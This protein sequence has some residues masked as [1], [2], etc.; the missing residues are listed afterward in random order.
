MPAPP[1]KGEVAVQTDPE[2]PSISGQAATSLELPQSQL[3][4]EPESQ[5]LSSQDAATAEQQAAK[6]AGTVPA[7]SE[8]ASVDAQA[9]AAAPVDEAD[10][11]AMVDDDAMDEWAEEEVDRELAR[12]RKEL[13]LEVGRAWLLRRPGD[14]YLH[15]T[16]MRMHV[17][18][19]IN[20]P[21]PICLTHFV[22]TCWPHT[23]QDSDLR[24]SATSL[25]SGV[26]VPALLGDAAERRATSQL[27]R[28]AADTAAAAALSLAGTGSTGAAAAAA[29]AA[30]A[31][32]A[33]EVAARAAAT[34]TAETAA[35][36]AAAAALA[37]EDANL[38]LDAPGT[39]TPAGKLG[40]GGT[41]AVP[42]A[43][44]SPADTL[45]SSVLRLLNT[46]SSIS[47]TPGAAA[48]AP[49]GAAAG[50]RRAAARAGAGNAGAAAGRAAGATSS[51][52]LFAGLSP[53]SLPSD[54]DDVL[55]LSDLD[56]EELEGMAGL[57]PSG[58][59][60]SG[61]A[62]PQQAPASARGSGLLAGAAAASGAARLPGAGA[63]AGAAA[64][65]SSS[66]SLSAVSDMS[67]I[68]RL[69][70]EGAS[71]V[72]TVLPAC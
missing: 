48:G 58:S 55:L 61:A 49:S 20:A 28:E 25:T 69:V 42:A 30:R 16:G 31:R 32:A 6:E 54:L 35:A 44:A 39:L 5:M 59:A 38:A 19:R 68:R 2:P 53:G 56:W 12:M 14:K 11:T 1:A 65:V 57:R 22:H 3:A 36:A 7:P 9:A 41:A 17:G 37:T 51:R 63:A 45:S 4:P 33:A 18:P 50:S 15:A 27:L 47:E 34:A 29:A 26:S 8:A 21:M 62:T 52:G 71:C 72:F 60:A 23:P 46:P 43:A 67:S 13:G 40:A 10:T 24:S 70:A 64:S 66:P